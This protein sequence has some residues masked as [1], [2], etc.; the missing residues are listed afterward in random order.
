M[1]KG[2]FQ[3]LQTSGFDFA[4]LLGSFNEATNESGIDVINTNVENVETSSFKNSLM[5]LNS[6]DKL[7]F[8]ETQGQPF[9]ET[10]SRS[11]GRVSKSVYTS[12][13]SATE[14]T[15]QVIFL[16]FMYIFTQIL[17]TGGDYWIS[18]WYCL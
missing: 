14:N 2:S 6:I 7:E 12:Y 18:F 9:Q 13:I 4:K 17:I 8:S 16:V 11:Y 1:A 15:F 5:S 10:E 3:E